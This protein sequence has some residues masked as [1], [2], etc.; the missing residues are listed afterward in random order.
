MNLKF[1]SNAQIISEDKN[2]NLVILNGKSL[3]TKNRAFKSMNKVINKHGI[4]KDFHS[5]SYGKLKF[6]VEIPSQNMPHF[7]KHLK[8]DHNFILESN[9]DTKNEKRNASDLLHIIFMITLT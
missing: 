3:L 1:G 5:Y 2:L 9:A 7:I 6:I 4:L 8:G